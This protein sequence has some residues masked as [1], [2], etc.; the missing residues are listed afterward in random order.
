MFIISVPSLPWITR[1]EQN[2]NL[3]QLELNRDSPDDQYSIK[4]GRYYAKQKGWRKLAGKG[5][6]NILKNE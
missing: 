3:R 6:E 4:L 5:N 2:T 1:M